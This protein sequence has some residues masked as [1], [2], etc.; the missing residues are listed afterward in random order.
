MRIIRLRPHTFL[1]D[2]YLSELLWGLGAA[3]N[4]DAIDAGRGFGTHPHKDMKF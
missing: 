1:A 3:I 4:D 2:Y